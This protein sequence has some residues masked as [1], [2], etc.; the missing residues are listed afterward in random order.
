M[1]S[2]GQPGWYRRIQDSYPQFIAELLV[3]N[4]KVHVLCPRVITFRLGVDI[5][6]LAYAKRK[7]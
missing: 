2:L 1:W 5:L 7:V 3:L 6:T 4:M